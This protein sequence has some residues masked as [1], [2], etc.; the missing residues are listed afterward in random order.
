MA[1]AHGRSTFISLG[2]DEIKCTTSS[3]ETMVDK[4]DV[5]VYGAEVHDFDRGLGNGTA[6]LGGIYDSGAAGPPALIKAV[7]GTKVAF[8]RRPEGTGSG[9]PEQTATVLVE[10]Y[11]ETSPVADMVTWSLDLQLTTAVVETTQS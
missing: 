11:T 7:L 1:Y 5:T 10:K 8:V 6:T 2:G 4:H 9:L 3:L